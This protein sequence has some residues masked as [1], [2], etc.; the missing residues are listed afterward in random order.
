MAILFLATG[1]TCVRIG[2]NE[3]KAVGVAGGL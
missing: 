3:D 2:E 1:G